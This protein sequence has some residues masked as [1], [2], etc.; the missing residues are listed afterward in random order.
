MLWGNVIIPKG[1]YDPPDPIAKLP[2][3]EFKKFCDRL[4]SSRSDMRLLVAR[5]TGKPWLFGI[6]TFAEVPNEK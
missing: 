5:G 4:A 6:P 2:E 3:K 1:K